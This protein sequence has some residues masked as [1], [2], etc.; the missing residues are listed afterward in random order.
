MIKSKAPLPATLAAIEA[1]VF[2]S[3]ARDRATPGVEDVMNLARG[4]NEKD[5][6][7]RDAYCVQLSAF[8]VRIIE[9]VE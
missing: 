1:E 3:R 2:Q 5:K 9:E 7:K 4:L 8:C 6:A